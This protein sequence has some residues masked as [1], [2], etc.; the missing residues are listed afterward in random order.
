MGQVLST[1]SAFER[2]VCGVVGSGDSGAFRV[3][4]WLVARITCQAPF[5]SQNFCTRLIGCIWVA[6]MP[7]L[8]AV[9]REKI[10][11][12]FDA[13]APATVTLDGWTNCIGS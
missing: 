3:V 2:W 9:I 1:A 12:S 10:R 6:G 11:T 13:L 4:E 5:D 7:F 8:G